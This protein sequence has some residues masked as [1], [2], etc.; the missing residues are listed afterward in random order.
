MI[1]LEV[2]TNLWTFIFM[3][4]TSIVTL[5][6]KFVIDYMTKKAEIEKSKQIDCYILTDEDIL[7]LKNHGIN[8]ALRNLNED[9]KVIYLASLKKDPQKLFMYINHEIF[10]ILH[11]NLEKSIIKVSDRKKM[12]KDEILIKINKHINES[13]EDIDSYLQELNWNREIIDNFTIWFNN[14]WSWFSNS[15]EDRLINE[16]CYFGMIDSLLDHTWS[17]IYAVRNDIKKHVN[18][19][20]GDIMRLM[21]VNEL[22]VDLSKHKYL[23]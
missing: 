4:G 2:I 13:K 7:K 22:N 12:S 23:T 9:F 14:H 15:I 21:S 19:Y 11:K 8:R 10:S 18:I 17:F 16:C 5:G 1:L 20:N 6:L 3:F